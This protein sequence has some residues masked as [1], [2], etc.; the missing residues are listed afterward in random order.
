MKIFFRILRY[1]P[2]LNLRLTQFFLFAI[3]GVLF[4]AVYLALIQPLIDILFNEAE[5]EAVQYPEFALSPDYF[6]KLYDYYYMNAFTEYGPLRALLFIC[7]LIVL[8]VLLSNVFRYLERL[9]A[10]KVRVVGESRNQV[11]LALVVEESDV[12]ARDQRF[13]CPQFSAEKN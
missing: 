3:L 13:Q 2:R 6:R 10:S 5:V 7:L 1:A 4:N 12:H 9:T 11:T 8:F